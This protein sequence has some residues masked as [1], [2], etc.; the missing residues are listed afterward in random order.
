VTTTLNLES[1]RYGPNHSFATTATRIFARFFAFH[2]EPRLHKA[3]CAPQLLVVVAKAPSACDK[4]ASTEGPT[5]VAGGYIRSK[6]L[7]SSLSIEHLSCLIRFGILE[8]TSVAA[9][10]EVDN[11]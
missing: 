2:E 7:I 1:K 6:R 3:S 9:L 8:R 11:I 10:S 5:P 4:G